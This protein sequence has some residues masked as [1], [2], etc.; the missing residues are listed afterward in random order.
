MAKTV[1]IGNQSFEKLR[2]EDCFYID[3]TYFI[4]EWWESKDEV[5]LITRPRRF[6]KTLNLNMIEC[7]FSP[8]YEGRADLF[9]GLSI[10]AD[11]AYRRLQGSYPVIFL[12]F[13]GIKYRDYD[14]AR[15]AM[16][17]LITN[18]YSLY[19]FILEDKGFDENER[20]EFES[21]S[22]EMGDETAGMSLNRLCFFLERYYGKKPLV[23]IDEYDTPMQEAW[24]NGYWDEITAYI[25]TLFNNTFKTNPSLGRG[26]LTGI[27]RVSKESIFSDLNNLEVIT[28][29]SDKYATAFGFTEDEV[30]D[31]LDAQGFEPG[32]KE[33][34]KKWYDG[35][36]FGNVTDIYNPWSVTNYLDK[37][38]LDTYWVN[39]SG[40]GLISRLVREGEAELKVDFEDLLRGKQLA[41]T[42][43]EQIAF[44][45]LG[46]NEEAIW[47]LL[48]AS[49]YLKV[50][51]VDRF[52]DDRDAVFTFSI[53]NMEVKKMFRRMIA[54]WF[55]ASGSYNRFV[56][57][58]LK[59]DEYE[60]NVYM[61]R[62]CRDTFSFFDT[63]KSP[64][65][66]KEPERFY[67]GFV[68]GLMADQAW[69][70]NIKSNRESGFGRYDVV[71]EPKDPSHVAVIIEFKVFDERRGEVS[72]SDTADAALAQ[73]ED[74]EYEADMLARGIPA[75]RIYKYGFAFE[76]EICL[77]KKREQI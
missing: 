28:V 4:K 24:L 21:I 70:Y 77:I 68:L 37:G 47:S 5:T 43:D 67:H 23:L 9:E 60:M 58:M 20:T 76:G 71:M 44:S 36:T 1:S 7:F 51:H 74:K 34:V 65:R 53:T 11:E 72:L 39:T 14:T 55:R 59:G 48:I 54:G 10:W 13:A 19:R 69:N 50:D 25:R 17:G 62:V 33:Q 8:K 49:G 41:A 6:G 27:T 52:A 63:G 12:S 61:E 57:A 66:R 35:F 32:E 31:A 3:K 18:V 46:E 29:T 22:R 40:N 2:T 30:F 38:I 16:N 64:S 45:Q 56:K 73:I 42:I 26:I 15:K 75:D